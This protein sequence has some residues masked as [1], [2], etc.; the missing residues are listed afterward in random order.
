MLACYSCDP[1][2]AEDFADACIHKNFNANEEI[3]ETGVGTTCGE[4]ELCPLR[5]VLR[6]AANAVCTEE[7][8]IIEINLPEGAVYTFT[9]GETES[10]GFRDN[11]LFTALKI[12][13]PELSMS[14]KLIIHGNGATFQ[15]DGST[16][17]NIPDHI[18]SIGEHS[19]VEIRDITFSTFENTYHDDASGVDANLNRAGGA[20]HNS[21]DLKLT[22]CRFIDCRANFGGAIFNAG[23]LSLSNCHFE[24][25]NIQESEEYDHFGASCIA[26]FE[27]DAILIIQSCTFESN[28]LTDGY[29]S[30]LYNGPRAHTSILSSNFLGNHNPTAPIIINVGDMECIATSFTNNNMKLIT[31]NPTGTL[32]FEFCLMENPLIDENPN[33]MVENTGELTFRDT[34]LFRFNLANGDSF[35]QNTNRLTI[36]GSSIQ[37]IKCPN[38]L[39]IDNQE[40][41]VDIENV[42]FANNE[43]Y[44]GTILADREGI[45]SIKQS[46][47]AFNKGLSVS[48]NASKNIEIVNSCFAANYHDEVIN[49]VYV[50]GDDTQCKFIHNSVVNNTSGYEFLAYDILM[51]GSFSQLVIQNNELKKPLS[52]PDLRPIKITDDENPLYNI[53]DNFVQSDEILIPNQI[54]IDE[55]L[56]SIVFSEA[57]PIDPEI[58]TRIIAS[59]TEDALNAVPTLEDVSIDRYDNIRSTPMTDAGAYE[60]D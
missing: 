58:Y 43:F 60:I 8:Q 21:G 36:I 15:F 7:D 57:D 38:G 12:N 37:Q 23:Q 51:E 45:I 19:K 54:T 44:I 6:T 20:I 55:S 39:L 28:S 26:N 34:R 30:V 1:E 22:D 3:G 48:G 16:D 10:L 52:S 9:D 24:N 4:E 59:P 31:N 42:I 49:N 13:T 17:E 27:R 41:Q 25:N 33:L 35:I 32:S 47:F 18:L 14:H 2:A 53:S 50:F 46:D 56:I 40:G 5:Y 29:M 11:D